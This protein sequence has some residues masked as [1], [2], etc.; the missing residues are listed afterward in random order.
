MLVFDN[1]RV[2]HGRTAFDPT[3]A[4]RHLRS[5]NV[6][7][8]GVHSAFRTLARRFAPEEAEAVLYQGAIFRGVAT[9]LLPPPCGEV[10]PQVRVG[11]GADH[12]GTQSC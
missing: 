8:D 6:D 5:C 2:L 3:L 11:A 9:E 10:G 12:P 1:Q 4:V 7:R